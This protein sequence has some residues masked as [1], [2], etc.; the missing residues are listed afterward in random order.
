MQGLFHG[1]RH[2]IRHC[3]R[4][5]HDV[6]KQAAGQPQAKPSVPLHATFVES[7]TI[8]DGTVINENSVPIIK[9]WRLRNTGTAPWPTGSKLIF[10]RGDRELSAAEE[11]PLPQCNPGETVDAYAEL[12][13][14]QRS[15]RYNA[16]FRLATAERD[17]FGPRLWADVN[18]SAVRATPKEEVK[19]APAPAPEDDRKPTRAPRATPLQEVKEVKSAAP[20]RAPTAAPAVPQTPVDSARERKW[21]FEISQLMSTGF[22]DRRAV[23]EAVERAEGDVQ[24]AYEDLIQKL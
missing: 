17:V 15:G 22:P 2:G 14:P 8:P 1:L 21:E 7:L 16:Y 9:K 11:F 19:S 3:V 12:V 13:L 6:V 5:A 10:F 24:R 20:V 18:V 4:R 23:V